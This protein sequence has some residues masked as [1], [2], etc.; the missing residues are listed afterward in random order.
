M[1]V[2]III[3]IIIIIIMYMYI[4]IFIFLLLFIFIFIVMVISY[5]YL[6]KTHCF[7]DREWSQNLRLDWVLYIQV[8]ISSSAISEFE[9]INSIPMH[10]TS[11]EL[12]WFSFSLRPSLIDASFDA[13]SHY[14]PNTC[15][16]KV[17]SLYKVWKKKHM[18]V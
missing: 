11:V 7:T 6:T 13:P 17:C 3:I 2:W 16:W 14:W 4:C 8:G 9:L 5:L 18:T 15:L 10:L 12:K 1:L